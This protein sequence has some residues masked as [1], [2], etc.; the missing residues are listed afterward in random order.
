LTAVAVASPREATLLLSAVMA[1]ETQFF[2]N[3]RP[4]KI[5]PRH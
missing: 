3:V 2:A 1:R 4:W 5:E